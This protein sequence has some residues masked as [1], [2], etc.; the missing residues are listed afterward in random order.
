MHFIKLD[1]H[2]TNNLDDFITSWSK[3]Y[4]YPLEEKYS[5][6]I[7]LCKFKSDDILELFT[8]K[9]GMK[10]STPKKESLNH[11]VLSK[12]DVIN[13]FKQ[14]KNIDVDSFKAEFMDLSAVWKI[15]LLHIVKPDEYPIYD[16]HIHRTYLFI[17]NQD[18]RNITNASISNKK[19]ELFYFDEYYKF[20]NGNK[21]KDL[22]IMDKACFAFG[23]FLKK[24]GDV[25]E[26]H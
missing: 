4:S 9:N 23:Q 5:K 14:Q 7:T 20:I 22:R 3:L 11:K 16:Q 10:L 1:F 12:L 21:I 6:H 19:K 13:S 2:S 17:T 26:T 24:Y 18:W 15:F 25:F 8:W